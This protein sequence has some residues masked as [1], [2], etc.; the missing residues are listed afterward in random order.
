[1]LTL[2]NA[3]GWSAPEIVQLVSDEPFEFIVMPVLYDCTKLNVAPL[4]TNAPL[5]T[6][7]ALD[8]KFKVV[9]E[10][11]V[12]V[13]PELIVNVPIKLYVPAGRVTFELTVV[14]L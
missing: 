14:R 5:T 12:S 3:S 6:R 8:G 13:A 1:M 10:L 4:A 11:S 2:L 9:P 7:S